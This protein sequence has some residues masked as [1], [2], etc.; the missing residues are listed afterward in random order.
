M[1]SVLNTIW[2]TVLD[3]VLKVVLDVFP[4]VVLDVVLGFFLRRRFRHRF[5]NRLICYIVGAATAPPA[6]SSFGST[7]TS[8]QISSQTL[9]NYY[10]NKRGNTIRKTYL[11]FRMMALLERFE[12]RLR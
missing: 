11:F 4:G 5:L 2:C 9:G 6:S 1:Y 7:T 3:V 8:P 10:S 12:D